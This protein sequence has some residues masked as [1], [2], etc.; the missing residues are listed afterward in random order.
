MK[1]PITGKEMSLQKEERTMTYRKQEFMVQYHYYLCKDSG[2][3]FTT[4]ELDELNI[5]QVYNQYRKAHN[6]PFPDEMKA[7][8]EKYSLSATKMADILGFGVNMYR[9]Y[10]SGEIPSESNARLIQLASDAEEFKKL[11]LLSNVFDGKDLDKVIKRIDEL[12]EEEKDD[13]FSFQFESYLLDK[14]LP[15]EYSGYRKPSL[16]K[17]TEMVVYF[18]EV[19]QPWKTKLNKLLFY[20]DFF[21]FKRTCFSISGIK[22][23]AIDMGP[24]PNNFNSLFEFMVNKDDIDI[25]VTE[26][27]KGGTGEQFKPNSRRKFNSDLFEEI[28]LKT[29]EEIANRFRSVSTKQII[30]ISHEEKAWIDN[31]NDGKKLIS[32]TYGFDLKAV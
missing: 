19:L 3:Q 29:M 30:D 31:F 14:H 13:F 8:R 15:D 10:E 7:L 21:Q 4:T 24:V 23:R 1:S 18:T 12:I 16:E 2:E 28:E 26:F 11:V 5:T 27:D 17:L 25:H 20:A 6:L 32:Y 22:Y 9:A